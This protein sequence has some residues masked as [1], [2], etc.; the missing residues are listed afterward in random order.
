[1]LN[2]QQPGEIDQQQQPIWKSFSSIGDAV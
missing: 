1:L 2:G